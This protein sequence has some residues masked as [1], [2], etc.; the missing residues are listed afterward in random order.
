MRCLTLA[1]AMGLGTLM[2]QAG[3]TAWGAE[4]IPL[5]RLGA[6][7]QKGYAGDGISI[8]ATPQG[9]RLRAA[10]QKLEGEV[11][12]AGLWLESTEA[13]GRERFRVVARALGRT[14]GV[15][16]GLPETGRVVVAGKSEVG[17][18][19][20]G[21]VEEYRVSMD[22]VRQD[23]V[24]A[25]RPE[26][27]GQLRV[28]L[29]VDGA[30][31]AP[32]G[33][34]VKLIL[35]GSGREIAY[36]RLRVTDAAGRELAARLAV[37]GPGGLTIDVEDAGAVYP[38]RIDPTFSDANWVSMGGVAGM[39]GGVSAIAFGPDGRM[40]VGGSFTVI[41]KVIAQGVAIWDGNTW[42]PL[43]SGPGGSVVGLKFLGAE[44]YAARSSSVVK[45]SGGE[46]SAVGGGMND[47]I[48]AIEIFD[49]ALYAGGHFTKAG[50]VAA[51]SIAKWD[52]SAWG[53]VG[54][55]M[56]DGVRVLM[57]SN[58]VLYAGGIFT[59]AGGVTA[60]CVAK[61]DGAQWSALGTGLTHIQSFSVA[62]VNTMA[63]NGSDLY[64]GGYFTH[65]GGL[66]AAN[67]AQWNGETWSAVG[68][69]YSGGFIYSLSQSGGQVYAA[70]GSKVSKWDGGTWTVVAS[71]LNGEIYELLVRGDEIFAA[72]GFTEANG[73]GCR[74]FAK[75]AD[76]NWDQIGG[77]QDELGLDGKVN[78]IAV[79][80]T[81]IYL[82]GNFTTAGEV[83]VNRIAKWDGSTWS[84]LGS[85][86]SG[87][88]YA[89]AASGSTVYAAG[90]FVSAGGVLALKLAKW[91]GS[92][93]S[94]L[95]SHP[96]TSPN[97]WVHALALVG[98]KL[99]VGGAFSRVGTSFPGSEV[100]ADNIASWDGSAW[101]GVG[102]GLN[103]PVN[104]LAMSGS[105]LYAG[106][107]F[108]NAGG[109]TANGIAK[110][111]G[112]TWSAVGQGFNG[113]TNLLVVAGGDIY[114]GGTFFNSVYLRRDLAKWNGNAWTYYPFT[115]L[116][117]TED[118]SGLAVVGSRLYVARSNDWRTW[119]LQ[120]WNGSQW[121]NV[122]SGVN[123]EIHALAAMGTDLY[124]GG[125]FTIAG[126]KISTY[127]ARV[128]VRH[129][130]ME[131]SGYV[132][133]AK[134]DGTPTLDDGT[135]FGLCA[136]GSGSVTRS[137][138]VRNVGT[139]EMNLTG[140]PK[141]AISGAAAGDFW[142][143]QEPA[144][145]VGVGESTTFEITFD[146]SAA[147]AREAT[148]SLT[149][150]DE[151]N[152]PF[153]FA[154]GGTGIAPGAVG[155]SS[156]RSSVSQ[157]ASEV[158]LTVARSGGTLPF[159]VTVKTSDGAAG[160][161][162]PFAPAVGGADYVDL[163]EEGMLVSFAQGEMSKEVTVALLP[164]SGIQPNKRFNVALSA[165]TNAAVLGTPSTAAVEILAADNGKPTLT[166]TAPLGGRFS[167]P[168]PLAVRGSAGD[169]KGIDRV[170]VVLNGGTAMMAELGGTMK[171]A[172]VRFALDILPAEGPN[173]LVVTAYDL[174]G[175][176]TTVTRNFTFTRRYVLTVSRNDVAMGTV[177]LTATPTSGASALS[178]AAAVSNPKTA[179]VAPGTVVKLTA[180]ANRGFVFNQWLGLP[181]GAAALGEVASFVMPGANVG[182]TAE[183]VVSPFAAPEG[184]TNVFYGL[185]QP[186]GDTAASNATVGWMTGSLTVAGAFSGKVCLD[187]MAQ[188]VVATFDG[189]GASVFT[190]G[191]K[192]QG[193]L[194]FGGHVLDLTFDAGEITATVTHAVGSSEGTATR[195]LF[196][197]GY[198]APV[199]LLNSAGRGYYTVAF[200][201]K[202]QT[203]A[204]NVA[205][206]PQGDGFGT[207]SL[208]SSGAV[209]LTGTLA[210]GTAVTASAALVA[211]HAC[212]IFAQLPT[213]G[214]P[215]R[216][217]GSLGGVLLFSS[218]PA[219]SDVTGG[220]LRWFRPADGTGKT[221]L[222]TNGWPNG[223]RVDAVGALYSTTM[224]VQA[225][226]GLG[227]V[228]GVNGNARLVFS[229]GKLTEAI[230]KT[231]FNIHGNAVAKI[232]AGDGS[233]ALT[234]APG[235]GG[236]S[237]S[238]VPNW[239]MPSAAKPVFKGILI[240]KGASKGGYGFFISNAKGDGDPEGGKVELG[241]GE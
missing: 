106:G 172:A 83:V 26:G 175:N 195:A 146:P 111:D 202:A 65:A 241:A 29:G 210:D 188:A 4:P 205:E 80:G 166:V 134:G 112:S 152:N 215:T 174:R 67:I 128:D 213:P 79:S 181:G 136:V 206:Y 58:G 159:A 47:D 191:G 73:V 116:Y 160:Q 64:V 57:T 201:A 24:V 37:A 129:S 165:P 32:A 82:A 49:G 11:T 70:M 217:G 50:G 66:S 107:D 131:L 140:I 197:S 142:V 219:D 43:G 225:G 85:G 108:T 97:G 133:I 53:P 76:G 115:A 94:R 157:G 39:D 12:E 220:D 104:C 30:R 223:I 59:N 163:T 171:P 42:S 169:A 153:A 125:A 113:R 239:A 233:F 69:G 1:V 162:P 226:L 25:Q 119:R 118:I 3:L 23:F 123:G 89:L 240:Q 36:S 48:E 147:G 196:S 7:A 185:I 51:K 218:A 170:E 179:T 234:L 95:G 149:S 15:M 221:A 45:W 78:A 61:W 81:D 124:T 31:T 158:V 96:F 192:R 200:P 5:E 54:G 121:V 33:S 214:A 184:G 92:T 35:A 143:T 222:Y 230:A 130:V 238:F 40:Y 17:F 21:L 151:D 20:P 132:T 178:P 90:D 135:E 236:F 150:D 237:G 187:G 189:G 227:A 182:M 102:S 68:S 22:G 63:M 193:T 46:W 137:F 60:K 144:A 145:V 127:L 75:F 161:A 198:Q 6:E 141:V 27:N 44:L 229:G 216:K 164:S 167:V 203:P 71:G 148:V 74:R 98:T 14:E 28:A 199:D 88:V 55:G 168:A 9:A 101:S 103:G 232:P 224:K 105:E 99:Y 62:G 209:A 18:V 228:D 176:S 231:N 110:W 100:P 41:G 139:R 114:A 183:F 180:R 13:A 86:V 8:E 235:T 38:V 207:M 122:G 34:G 77:E 208:T 190:V 93:W 177:G 10:F 2:S 156:A 154:I 194:T 204:V 52:G 120:H 87:E 117:S 109:V 186:E 84:G 155:F 19:R 56:N 173:T 72:G 126:G 212:P 211:G 138:T 16:R 91:D